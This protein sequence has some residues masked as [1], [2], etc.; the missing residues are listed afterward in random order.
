MGQFDSYIDPD[1]N[2]PPSAVRVF[3]LVAPVFMIA[4]AVRSRRLEDVL[5]AVLF[6]ALF[7]PSGIAPKAYRARLDAL[8]KRLLP[9]TVAAFLFMLCGLFV[10][11]AKFLGLSRPTSLYIALP[12]AVVL[13]AVGA[14]RQ[15]ARIRA[16]G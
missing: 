7:V 4:E 10:L 6:T 15:Q 8:D 13:A 11:L 1:K 3:V 2:P 12:A 5:L 16:A 9:S 14:V